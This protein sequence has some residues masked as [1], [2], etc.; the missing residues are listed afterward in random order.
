MYLDAHGA[1]RVLAGAHLVQTE[2]LARRVV[3][4]IMVDLDVCEGGVELHVNVTQPGRE[5]ERR[6]CV[7]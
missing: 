7:W 1:R 2:D 5:L 3:E 6:H 4:L